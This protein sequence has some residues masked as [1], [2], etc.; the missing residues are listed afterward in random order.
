MTEFKTRLNNVAD[1]NEDTAQHFRKHLIQELKELG[2]PEPWVI[3]DGDGIEETVD[4][5]GDWVLM[6]L[7]STT[8][9]NQL[10]T[11]FVLPGSH[12]MQMYFTPIDLWTEPTQYPEDIITALKT[13]ANPDEHE[14]D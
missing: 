6:N 11:V 14:H 3:P 13:N 2:I 1:L 8:N 12:N 5:T 4:G 7:H 9:E 10:A